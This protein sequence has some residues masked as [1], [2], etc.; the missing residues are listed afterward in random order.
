MAAISQ[1]IFSDAF[2]WMKNF[3]ILNIFS[4]KFVSK[5]PIDNNP[6]MVYIMTWRQAII[7]SN[8]DPIHWRIYAALGEMSFDEFITSVKTSY[9]T[10]SSNWFQG[11]EKNTR[12]FLIFIPVMVAVLACPDEP[13][14][15]NKPQTI[16]WLLKFH[17]PYH[18][19]KSNPQ[20]WLHLGTSVKLL[21]SFYSLHSQQT[22]L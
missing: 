20:G 15:V 2:S 9:G 4:L 12:L 16:N 3:C 5:D 10:L 1:T 19:Y 22:C 14:V 8:A 13:P 18:R 6:A 21:E 7:W 11:F 17:A